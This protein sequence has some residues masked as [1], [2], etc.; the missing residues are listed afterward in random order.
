MAL[1]MGKRNRDN[2][3]DPLILAEGKADPPMLDRAAASTQS[4]GEANVDRIL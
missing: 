4:L 3:A 2:D 1:R